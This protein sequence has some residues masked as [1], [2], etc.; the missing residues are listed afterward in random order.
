VENGLPRSGTR[1]VRPASRS[2]RI[3]KQ[4]LWRTFIY[5]IIRLKRKETKIGRCG[6]I[7]K[8][9]AAVEVA[10]VASVLLCN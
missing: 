8:G 4:A 2:R 1:V 10:S 3:R 9:H 6:I 5:A 7:N